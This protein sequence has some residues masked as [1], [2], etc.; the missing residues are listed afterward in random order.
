M[1]TIGNVQAE[2]NSEVF[3]VASGAIGTDVSCIVNSD[4]TVSVVGNTSVSAAIGTAVVFESGHTSW[5]GVTYDSNSDRI[6]VVYTDEGNSYYGKAVVGQVTAGN[7]SI[8]FGTPVIYLS[9]QTS[10]SC[11]TFDSSNNKVVVSYVRTSDNAAYS[12]VATVDPSDNS[13]SFGTA[14]QFE[15]ESS[16]YVSTTFDSSSNKVVVIYGNAVDE[17]SGQSRIGTV[18]GTDISFGT[19]ATFQ[20]CSGG[21]GIYGTSC[22][23]DSTANKVLILYANRDDS[24]KLKVVVSTVSGTDISFG[25]PVEISADASETTRNTITFDST[26]NR[27]VVAYTDS[28]NTNKGTAAVG[29]TSGTTISFG[30]PVVFADMQTGT[31]IKGPQITFD[32]SV[33]KVAVQVRTYDG[34]ST[35][36]RMYAATVD[37]SD[38]S[39]SFDTH[40]VFNTSEVE[41]LGIT[42]DSTSEKVVMIWGDPAPVTHQGTA[43]VAQLAGSVGNLTS[44]NYIGISDAAYADTQTATIQ[45]GGAINTGQSSL[46]IGQQYF[47]QTD[48]TLGLSADDPSVIAGTAVSATDIIVKG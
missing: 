10:N 19:R 11:A 7:N 24:N 14:V 31:S 15:S 30:T 42:Y 29:T 3:A 1:K 36:G 35:Q 6:V 48:G 44:E 18:S 46:T 2:A 34:S 16:A 12:S 26:N 32:A 39:I 41:G 4:G 22:A 43:I 17:H 47:V 25:T 9:A 21:N 45:A 37:P 33:G 13:I 27:A 23:F 38:N 40:V 28:G 20:V 5:M 8:S